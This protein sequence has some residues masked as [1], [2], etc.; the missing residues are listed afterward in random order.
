MSDLHIGKMIKDVFTQSGMSVS[1]FAKEIHSSRTNIYDIFSRENIDVQLLIRISEVLDYDFLKVI[2]EYIH[3]E[4]KL[5]SKDRIYMVHEITAHE[6]DDL[7]K[8]NDKIQIY[9]TTEET[10]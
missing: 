4:V 2:Y 7:K 10:S 6:L 9:R 8:S 5:Q 3:P 1:D